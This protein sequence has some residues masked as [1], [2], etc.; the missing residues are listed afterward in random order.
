M[1]VIAVFGFRTAAFF[2]AVMPLNSHQAV[3][4]LI[5]APPPRAPG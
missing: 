5:S 4:E 1:A 3:V 2:T